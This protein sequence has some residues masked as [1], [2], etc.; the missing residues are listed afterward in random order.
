MARLGEIIDASKLPG[1][2][3]RHK[4][5]GI[6][7][8][9]TYLVKNNECEIITF[10]CTIRNKGIGSKLL[11]KIIEQC[12]QNK[13]AKIWLITTNDNL[14]ALR[15]FQ[16]R[17]FKIAHVYQDAIKESRK[18]KPQIP[19]IGRYGIPIRDEIQLELLL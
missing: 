9:L 17:G 14:D 2:I 13:L 12:R 1:L 16:K 7:A 19:H 3:I 15:F 6:I 11:T 4:Y 5:R 10:N 8:L 18:L